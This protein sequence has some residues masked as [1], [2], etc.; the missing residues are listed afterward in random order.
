MAASTTHAEAFF[1]AAFS[2][3]ID[4]HWER[5]NRTVWNEREQANEERE[6]VYETTWI[7]ELG[8][9]RHFLCSQRMAKT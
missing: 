9:W 6:L 2:E 4:T 7:S 8:A 3:G 5:E 1:G